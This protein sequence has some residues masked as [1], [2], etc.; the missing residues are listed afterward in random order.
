LDLL[1]RR[2]TARRDVASGAVFRY[3]VKSISG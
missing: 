3:D 1:V 2:T